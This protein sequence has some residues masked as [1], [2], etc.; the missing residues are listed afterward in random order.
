MTRKSRPFWNRL[1]QAMTAQAVKTDAPQRLQPG[2]CPAPAGAGAAR[3]LTVQQQWM[4]R[5][6]LQML[7]HLRR[8]AYGGHGNCAATCADRGRKATEAS[9]ATT[10]RQEVV[11]V[12]SNVRNYQQLVSGLKPGTEVVVLDAK[13]RAAAD[14]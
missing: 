9:P 10:Q 14:C 12:D 3:C 1:T 11:F 7:R 4:W 5:M 6:R 8:R 13:G 2:L